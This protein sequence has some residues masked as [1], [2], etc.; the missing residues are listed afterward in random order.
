MEALAFLEK[1]AALLSRMRSFILI[2]LLAS[3]VSARE[4]DSSAT[5]ASLVFKDIARAFSGIGDYV[6]SP[7]QFNRVEW[8]AA[9]GVLAG[10]GLLMSQD[11]A[12]HNSVHADG[13]NSYN[14]D[15]WDVPTAVGDFAGAGGLAA[16]LYGVGLATKSDELRVTGRL[17]VESIAS[18]GLTALTVR[19]LIRQESALHGRR[20]LAL[21]P[22]RVGV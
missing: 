15:F 7:L 21:S 19:V 10:T 3:V 5:L 2:L 6:T 14:G 20:P 9:G 11:K 13:R 17:I 1:L 22:R 8:M 12:I 18:A 16:V 4:I